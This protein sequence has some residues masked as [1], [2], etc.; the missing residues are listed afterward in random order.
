MYNEQGAV[1]KSEIQDTPLIRKTV[2]NFIELNDIQ[3]KLLN[4]I[5]DKL[6]LILNKR[7]PQKEP[8]SIPIKDSNTDFM[9]E[10]NNQFGRLGGNNSRLSQILSHLNQ[11]A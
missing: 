4:E 11:I 10:M 1:N 5:E 8:N 7:Q 3:G 9:S 6:H 2:S